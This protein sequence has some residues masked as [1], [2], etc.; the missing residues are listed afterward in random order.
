[1]LTKQLAE[2]AINPRA[3][4]IPQAVMDGARDALVDTLGC[5]LAGTLDEVTFCGRNGK[6]AAAAEPS[7][8]SASRAAQDTGTPTNAQLL[9]QG[10]FRR[11]SPPHSRYIRVDAP[12]ADPRG[13]RSPQPIPAV[14]WLVAPAASSPR[15]RLPWRPVASSAALA[16]SS[17]SYRK[18]AS[19]SSRCRCSSFSFSSYQEEID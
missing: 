3:S 17:F 6:P 1:M 13:H 7:G 10:R 8:S 12:E 14:A 4:A 5:T 18:S 2:F 19:C 16:A 15:P 11:A 9:G